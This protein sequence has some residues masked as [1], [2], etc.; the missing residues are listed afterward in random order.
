MRAKVDQCK[1]KTQ[2][3]IRLHPFHSFILILRTK[4]SKS[5]T[6]QQLCPLAEL[7]GRPT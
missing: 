4:Q 2:T 1:T 7:L 5:T 6:K 3:T